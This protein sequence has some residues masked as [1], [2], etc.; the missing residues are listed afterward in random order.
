MRE[1]SFAIDTAWVG[2]LVS[3]IDRT[4]AE[5]RAARDPNTQQGLILLVEDFFKQLSGHYVARDDRMGSAGEDGRRQ[6]Q[7]PLQVPRQDLGQGNLGQ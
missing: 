2:N 4:S 7:Y 3:A 6:F 1:T 5:E